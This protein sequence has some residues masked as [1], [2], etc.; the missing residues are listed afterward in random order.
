ME[1]AMKP[2][3][4]FWD[5]IA[6][7]YARTP[8]ADEAAYQHKL[9]ITQSYLHQEMELLEFGCGTGSTALEHAR[10]VKHILATDI[11]AKML[12]IAKAKSNETGIRNITFEEHAIDTF[13]APGESFDAVLGL[14]IVHLV[15]DRD[16][17]IANVHR[18]LKPGGVFISS[19]VCL[20]DF[21]S[22]MKYVFPIGRSLGFLPLVKVFK[23][24]DLVQ[25]IE[26]AGFTI[27]YSWRPAK[28]K[29]AF[30]VARKA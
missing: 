26:R 15:A 16:A 9:K 18:M 19:T 2:S 12:E 28:N 8:V 1:I 23:E 11:S 29:A 6:E 5:R 24:S 14:S 13:E 25:S 10:Y 20:G 7:K 27:D 22:Y 3:A 30:I 17:V 21:M 4:R